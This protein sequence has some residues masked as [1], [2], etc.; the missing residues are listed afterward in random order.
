MT[1]Q[2]TQLQQMLTQLRTR[3]LVMCA[4]TGIALEEACAAFIT[5]NVGRAEAV[6]EGDAA[7][8]ALENEIDAMALSLMVRSQPVAHDLRFV[9]GAL[10]MVIDLERIG[11]E[12]AD[13]AERVILMQGLPPLPVMDELVRLMKS[14]GTHYNTAV[15]AFR[16]GNVE[17]ALVICR[18]EDEMTQEEV[19]TLQH[20]MESSCERGENNPPYSALH[21][22]LI[23]RSLNRISR[24]SVNIAEHA[25]FIAEGRDMKHKKIGA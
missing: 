16:S 19:H 4:S 24:R 5:G 12:A 7:I 2:E 9:V 1:R 23:C 13:I 3:L 8:D 20:I 11:D 15:E 10:R 22:I 6:L 14:A 17:Q 25:I 21:S 18:L